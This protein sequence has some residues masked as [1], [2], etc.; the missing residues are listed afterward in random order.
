MREP[1]K[2]IL[3]VMSGRIRIRQVMQVAV[4]I[5]K[6]LGFLRKRRD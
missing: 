6:P 2:Q 1:E 3:S 4:F 5:F